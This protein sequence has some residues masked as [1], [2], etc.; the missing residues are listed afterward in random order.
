MSI[1]MLRTRTAKPWS[2]AHH[3][4]EDSKATSG[5]P[6]FYKIPILGWLFKQQTIEKSKRELLIFVTPRIVREKTAGMAPVKV[7]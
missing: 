4:E 2:S 6:W 5:V 1:P 7:N 3:E